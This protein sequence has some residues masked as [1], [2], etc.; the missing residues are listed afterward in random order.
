MQRI[1]LG[2]QLTRKSWSVLRADGSL[3]LFPVISALSTICLLLILWGP[4][5]GLG[6]VHMDSSSSN[7]YPG[8]EVVWL[9]VGLSA[10]L[11]TAVA[12][13]CNVALASCTALS[14]QGEDTTLGQGFSLALSRWRQV[15]GWALIATTVNLILRSLE[16]RLPLAGKLAAGLVG[17]A[18]TLACMFVIPVLALE[19]VSPMDAV[20]RSAQTFKARWGEGLTGNALIGA[21]GGIL[22]LLVFISAIAGAGLLM[23]VSPGLAVGWVLLM[24][25]CWMVAM[26]A[27]STL[28]QVFLV[29]LYLYSRDGQVA[30]PFS[31]EE[32]A[33]AFRPARKR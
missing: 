23:G 7:V 32:F 10:Y 26:V 27:L 24:I 25:L 20:R 8:Q 33:A 16:E 21:L 9:I 19:G 17:L 28:N 2:W 30:G 15:L 11:T 22:F 31:A 1:R 6:W 18:W 29:A 14:L 13:F 3:A 4:A 12:V 5:L